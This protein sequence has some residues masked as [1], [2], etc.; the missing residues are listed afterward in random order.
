[1]STAHQV[2]QLYLDTLQF[3]YQHAWTYILPALSAMT[4]F[5]GYLYPQLFRPLLQQLVAIFDS[6]IRGDASFASTAELTRRFE[7]I[8]TKTLGY[9]ME[10]VGVE[11][12]MKS[13]D[14]VVGMVAGVSS[15]DPET[16]LPLESHYFLFELISDHAK[17]T[18]SSLAFFFQE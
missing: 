4:K 5:L 10:A 8:L 16:H 9:C 12:F 1:M 6:S 11:E 13:L 17:H 7:V 3:K 18:H 15:Q 2:V 14:M